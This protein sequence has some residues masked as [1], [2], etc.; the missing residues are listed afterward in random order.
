MDPDAIDQAVSELPK[1]AVLA[2]ESDAPA[3]PPEA[4]REVEAAAAAA[5]DAAVDEGTPLLRGVESAAASEVM[6]Q[7]Q[8]PETNVAV[9]MDQDVGG[10]EQHSMLMEHPMS[11]EGA[12]AHGAPDAQYPMSTKGAHAHA[13]EATDAQHLMPTKGAD[14]HRAPD[15]QH[16]MLV[17]GPDTYGAPD[18]LHPMLAEEADAHG[19]PDTLHPM[20]TEDAYAHGAPDAQ[21]PMPTEGAN[22]HG[23]PEALHPMLM[24]GP[25][26]YGA[27]DAEHS[28]PTEGADAQH[29]MLTERPDTY[30]AHDAQHPMLIEGPDTYGAH[31]AQHSMPTE[32]AD[33][34]GAPD[35]QHPML[36]E[37]P[38]TY[39]AHDAHEAPNDEHP[40]PTEGADT[41]GAPNAHG[42]HDAQHPMLAE[43]PD[44]Y[45][46]P[47]AHGAHDAQHPMLME[48]AAPE[49][50]Q[51]VGGDEGAELSVVPPAVEGDVMHEDLSSVQAGA[52]AGQAGDNAGAGEH[53]VEEGLEGGA[54]SMTKDMQPSL[55]E[56]L[57]Q[58]SHQQLGTTG[59]GA[60]PP[61]LEG[62]LA[63]ALHPVGMGHQPTGLP[64]LPQVSD[65]QG[66]GPSSSTDA[67]PAQGEGAEGEKSADGSEVQH[68]G[69]GGSAQAAAAG[70]LSVASLVLP[71]ADNRTAAQ[72]QQ[73]LSL[74]FL[75][76]LLQQ[77][78]QTIQQNP[79]LAPPVG[80]GGLRPNPL[81]PSPQQSK[82]AGDT[83]SS[84]AHQ[85]GVH[86]APITIPPLPT[87]PM[88]S[89]L[90]TSHQHQHQRYH[91]APRH[92]GPSQQAENFFCI[93]ERNQGGLWCGR[94]LVTA[95]D[96]KRFPDDLKNQ[97]QL[98][99][100]GFSTPAEAAKAVDSLLY[101][102]G[103]TDKLNFP[104]SADERSALDALGLGGLMAVFRN[105]NK[106]A[107]HGYFGISRVNSEGGKWRGRV[108]VSPGERAKILYCLGR[109]EKLNFPMSDDEKTA[110]QALGLSGVMAEFR[111]GSHGARQAHTGLSGV[112][113]EF[114]RGSHG[115]K[116]SSYRGVF[117]HD[118]KSGW[119]SSIF[120][121]QKTLHLGTYP[122]E[123]EAARAYDAAAHALGF[124]DKLN[125][126]SVPLPL[127]SSQLLIKLFS[128][129][130]PA[131]VEAQK[132]ML[133]QP[134]SHRSGGPV[135]RKFCDKLNF[136]SDPLPPP[137][138]QLL[139][140]LFNTDDPASVE[141]QKAMLAQPA[142]HRSGGAVSRKRSRPQKP[143]VGPDGVE[144]EAPYNSQGLNYF[145]GLTGG[146]GSSPPAEGG[147]GGG[148]G[149]G[150][151]STSASEAAVGAATAALGAFGQQLL[152]GF[153]GS[154]HPEPGAAP[155]QAG[156]GPGEG[157]HGHAESC[158]PAGP[159]GTE[160][161]ETSAAADM[162]HDGA[163][164]TPIDAGHNPGLADPGADDP[165]GSSPP[166]DEGNVS[167]LG[168]LT[169]G[170]Q[171]ELH[172]G[173][174]N[175]S[176]Q[177]GG[178]QW[179]NNGPPSSS[180]PQL[181]SQAPMGSH[182][183]NPGSTNPLAQL[184]IAPLDLQAL[185]GGA[186]AQLDMNQTGLQPG[187]N[188][189]MARG[190]QQQRQGSYPGV[191]CGVS[192]RWQGRAYIAASEH[193]LLP[194]HLQCLSALTTN[195]FDSDVEAAK[196]LDRYSCNVFIT[197]IIITNNN[198]TFDS[199]IGAAK[200]LDR[201][202]Y[203]L[204]RRD[205]LNFPMSE[206]E[207]AAL[208]AL[209]VGGVVAAFRGV[210]QCPSSARWR[211]LITLKRKSIHLGTFETEDE[212]ARA[213]DQAARAL[214]PSF[215]LRLI[216]MI[217]LKGAVDTEETTLKEDLIESLSLEQQHDPECVKAMLGCSMTR[218]AA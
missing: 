92:P 133:A 136:P 68:G 81:L 101:L 179:P 77:L 14:A 80:G 32:E 134:A 170:L 33:A 149:G 183:G 132:A 125:F 31:D 129:D 60:V 200:A 112:M 25:D 140:K 172:N 18:A 157:G 198:N 76:P 20:L 194:E 27:P 146:A 164:P 143:D 117:R 23:A 78:Q 16:P 195:T 96:C 178:M 37:G 206:D 186:S 91:Q 102:L 118:Q 192:G 62:G 197:T 7:E 26:T 202:L 93:K 128:T 24:E 196:A 174:S 138:S 72:Q 104:M 30:G 75:L 50:G 121:N 51:A 142:S 70:P 64:G 218:L 181:L 3:M 190:L 175:N 53:S 54:A 167:L 9:A 74:S 89:L 189:P 122:D 39:G 15:A 63:A 169:T 187:S 87:L 152:E 59:V 215:R 217:T 4:G 116:T 99:T 19:A 124:C 12:G 119:V 139:I 45:G 201:L 163:T 90:P 83:L 79:Q 17:E 162:D 161:E 8:Q 205:K 97:T 108:H 213:Y 49:G 86:S 38:D 180:A 151:P 22:F 95:K 199:D 98:C 211:G 148:G 56:L 141:A 158:E 165:G 154:L 55:L 160:G 34:H 156:G 110:L 44:T 216:L 177:G 66:V 35:A 173:V 109:E 61:G 191:T 29:H 208:D 155:P 184:H 94:V 57:L 210:T 43:G 130:D 85:I 185:I 150:G 176:Q 214:G 11:T 182:L 188:R 147:G 209:G 159:L 144:E 47:D 65:F 204:G 207:R 168:Q 153:M 120:L 166:T 36:M 52:E 82:G 203:T 67:Q 28:M 13:Y 113:A 10:M 48:G 69:E 126:P 46:A 106:R 135:S 73:A 42:A 105:A 127:P 84:G 145:G 41:Y 115:G 5:V 171:L 193:K 131:S 58:V 114:R 103:R 6:V 21:H 1:E 2:M 123:E 107:T 137:S 40:M 111:R 71:S 88:N 212:A 100:S